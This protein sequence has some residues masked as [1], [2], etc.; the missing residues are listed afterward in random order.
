MRIV[1]DSLA[2]R[3]TVPLLTEAELADIRRWL[4]LTMAAAVPGD[5][6]R[7]REPHRRFHFA[8]FAHAGRRLTE[9]VHDL[10]DHAERYRLLYLQQAGD[11]ISL[12]QLA[13]EEH[14]AILAA[15]EAGDA[16]LCARRMAEHLAR[17]ALMT[18]VR[19]DHRH[20]PARLRASLALVSADDGSLSPRRVRAASVP[21]AGGS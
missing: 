18:I 9:R 20:D 12:I 2:V 7:Y 6:A 16:A 10:W 13:G 5:L 8:L 4:D 14:A 17:T 11:Q 15:A 19:V 21:G 3:I 1:L